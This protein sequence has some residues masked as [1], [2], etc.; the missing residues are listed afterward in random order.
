MSQATCETC[1]WWERLHVTALAKTRHDP[2][3]QCRRFPPS[4]T[5]NTLGANMPPRTKPDDTCGEHAER[6]RAGKEKGD[7]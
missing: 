5:F 1:L 7:D 2:L 3:G 4:G 6:D